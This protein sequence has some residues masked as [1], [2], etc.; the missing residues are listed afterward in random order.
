MRAKY[1]VDVNTS[2]TTEEG[3]YK[4]A[5]VG[6]MGLLSSSSSLII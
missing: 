4:T 6:Q 1:A 2:R 3:A 5:E